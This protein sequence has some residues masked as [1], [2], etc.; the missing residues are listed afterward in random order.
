MSLCNSCPR[1]CNV[2]RGEKSGVCGV[3]DKIKIARAALHFG[4]EPFISG[5][6][7]SGTIFFSGC[8]LKC[9]MCQNYKISHQAYGKEIT[10]K[11]LAEIMKE[12]EDNGAHNI[13]FVT[14]SHYFNQI[15]EALSI[16]RPKIPLVYNSSGY[17]DIKNISK[18]LFDIYLFD[19]KFY[20]KEKSIRYAKCDNYFDV[21]SSVIKKAVSLVGTPTYDNDGMM[22]SGVVV[23]HL[24]LPQSTNDAIEIIKWLEK[25]TP[26]IVLSLMS[27]YV[28]YYK[29][30]DFKEL[31]RKI[32]SREYN[33][34]L[35]ECYNK[36]FSN[37]L[38]QELASADTK[39]IP[40]FNLEGV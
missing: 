25:E 24:I 11:R 12:L 36:N 35:I 38:I 29:A 26:Q 39:Y 30:S 23:R 21:A 22:K 6:N 31:S 18:N 37:I 15:Q 3:S 4:E 32:T 34:V 28:P 19:L 13:N 9:V 27:Q 8:A 2:N 16:Y 17:D 40:D 33:K 20:T 10:V 14:P 1:N 7:G 5:E